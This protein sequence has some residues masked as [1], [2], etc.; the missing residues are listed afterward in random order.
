MIELESFRAYLDVRKPGHPK[1]IQAAINEQSGVPTVLAMAGAWWAFSTLHVN[2]I[3]MAAGVIATTVFTQAAAK[4]VFGWLARRRQ[5]IDP[6]RYQLYAAL[7]RYYEVNGMRL[8]QKKLDPVAAELLEAGS[9][10]WNRISQIMNGGGWAELSR[11]GGYYASVRNEVLGAADAAMDEL[12]MLCANCIGDPARSPQD[13]LKGIFEDLKDL[14]LGAVG[15]RIEWLASG[16]VTRYAHQSPHL[17]AI[18][19]PSRELAERLKLLSEEVDRLSGEMTSATVAATESAMGTARI[20]ALIQ[21]L[22]AQQ[23]AE[24]ELDS[25]VEQRPQ[26]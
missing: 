7:D 26:V 23:A 18:F 14:K 19:Q 24:S 15:Q 1:T 2:W 8:L 17:N 13:D 5:P 9:Y 11:D 12:A 6:R 21:N 25:V 16:N 20:D 3:T 22:R 10:Y 4:C